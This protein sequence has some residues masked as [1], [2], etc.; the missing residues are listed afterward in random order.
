MQ[1]VVIFAP[2]SATRKLY[3]QSLSKRD[4]HTHRAANLAELLLILVTFEID[5]IIL[6]DEGKLL[7]EFDLALSILYRKFNSKRV[8]L[9]SPVME[10]TPQTE[11]YG[12][13]RDFFDSVL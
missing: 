9:V 6:V 5:T 8:I 13:S 10:G 3:H 11:L 1:N 4:Y 7:H 12:S 2:T